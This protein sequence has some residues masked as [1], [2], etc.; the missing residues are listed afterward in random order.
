VGV[1][2]GLLDIEISLKI[3]MVSL[4]FYARALHSTRVQCAVGM[5]FRCLA[6]NARF[7][8]G[9][10]AREAAG[11]EGWGY[12]LVLSSSR[13]IQCQGYKSLS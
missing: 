5:S 4:L 6:K 2:V 7:E 13:T 12:G 9:V 10:E 3:S 1:D 8:R 11:L